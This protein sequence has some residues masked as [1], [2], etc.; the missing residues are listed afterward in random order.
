MTV[1]AIFGFKT[2]PCFDTLEISC[3]NL[4]VIVDERNPAQI[5]METRS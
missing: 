3:L 4:W 2:L 5:G 1:T